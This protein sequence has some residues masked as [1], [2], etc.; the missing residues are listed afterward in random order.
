[1]VKLS[2]TV[3]LSAPATRPTSL[4]PRSSVGLV[5]A[6]GG[7]AWTRSGDG[8][9]RHFALAN[10]HEDLG[11]GSDDGEAGQ[12][13]EIQ[14]R[15]GVHAA[16][17]TIEVERGQRERAGETLRQHDL[18]N[19]ACGDVVLGAKDDTLVIRRVHHGFHSLAQL[20]QGFVDTFRSPLDHVSRVAAAR[21]ERRGDIEA[22]AQA[23]EDQHE[24]GPGK[25]HVG[26][27]E[28]AIRRAGQG[29]DQAD[30]LIPEV[31][32]QA[33]QRRRQ[34]LGHVDPAG[35]RQCAE[36]GHGIAFQRLESF[37]IEAPCA[38][39]LGPR[40]RRAKQQVRIET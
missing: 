31:S 24:S 26:Q 16:Q 9:D 29:F 39:D 33:R 13:E 25:E 11:A 37:S 27:G 40:S 6:G 7:P 22:V 21:P 23:V 10:A 12:V 17:C 3:T 19:I 1:M 14:E 36:F 34:A 8:T 2:V 18:E 5:L 15:R 35:V 38:V 4:R 32:D 20:A 28:F 30:G